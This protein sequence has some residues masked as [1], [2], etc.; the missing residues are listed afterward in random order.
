MIDHAVLKP[1][2]KF[3][4]VRAACE[5][6][7]EYR[8]GSLFV[9]PCEVVAARGCLNGSSVRLGTVIGFPH[10]STYTKVKAAEARQA[11]ADGVVELDMVAN[12]GRLIDTD[13]TYVRD[14]V[15]AVV[16][17]AEGRTVKV[18]IECCC[19]NR[20]QMRLACDT[21]AQAGAA[22]VKTSTGFA[23]TGATVEDVHFLRDC[24]GNRLRVKAA[25]GIRTL[26]DAFA[27][28]QAGAVRIG[29]S[30]SAEILDAMPA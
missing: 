8:I 4:D 24:V 25:G 16:S 3:A 17:A 10:G 21:I 11:V 29:T 28:I 13:A 2:A 27:M 23:E 19:L 14:D 20:D 1:E 5:L 26:S 15:A 30:R 12:I 9:K 6:A 18:I 7:G 22:F